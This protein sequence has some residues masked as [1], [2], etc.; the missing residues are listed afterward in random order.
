MEVTGHQTIGRL[1]LN[2]KDYRK[3]AGGSRERKSGM[4]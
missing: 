1:I 2:A 3:N 4:L